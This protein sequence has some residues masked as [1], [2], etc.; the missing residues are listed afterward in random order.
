MTGQITNWAGNVAFTPAQL[1]RPTSLAELRRV[2]AG[3]TQVRVLGSG[4]SFNRIA[5][6]TGALVSVGDLPPR[7][8][9]DPANRRVTVAAGIRLGE[10]ATRLHAEGYALGNLPSLPHISVAGA[11]ATAT[12][13]SGI[14]NGNLATAVSAI[15]LVTADGDLVTVRRGDD[16][17]FD[18]TVVALGA[19]G[20]VTSLTLD[21]VPTFEV[22]QYLYEN[23]PLD[24]LAEQLDQVL[25]AAYSVSLFT[26]WTADR[27]N[28][29]WLKQRVEDQDPSPAETWLGATLAD[30]PRHPVPGMSATYATAQQGQPGPWHERLP[31]FQLAFTPSS[32]QE[33]QSEYFVPREQA[34]AAIFAIN[35]IRAQVAPVLQICELRTI[36]ADQL[37]LSPSYQRDSLALH[38]TWIPD[39]AAVTPVVAEIERQLSP[40]AARPHWGKV[41]TMTTATLGARYPRLTDFVRLA[42]GYDP[43]SKFRNA[44]IDRYLPRIG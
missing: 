37:W 9:L 7:V 17:Q 39:T 11:C 15:E 5:D 36:A 40:F 42:S 28:Q 14:R 34:G 2:V 43:A 29:V 44:F 19:L 6:T 4:H 24:R 20:V 8:D 35:A 26:D 30:G 27:I 16:E 3:N 41:F 31:H 33:L 23:L 32:G 12:H 13:G 18:G 1:H 38:F 25:S 22:R 21:V 10:L